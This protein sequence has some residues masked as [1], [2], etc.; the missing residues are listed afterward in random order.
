MTKKIT[1]GQV[2]PFIV[3]MLIF[4]AALFIPSLKSFDN[5][6]KYNS[7]GTFWIIV[8]TVLVFFLTPGLAFLYGGMVHLK[9]V[10]STMIKS[11]VATGIVSVFGLRNNRTLNEQERGIAEKINLRKIDTY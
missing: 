9:N 6:G 3:L 2:I 11:F 5:G 8:T 4:I 10:I 1:L 7:A